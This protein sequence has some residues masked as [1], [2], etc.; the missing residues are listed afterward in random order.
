MMIEQIHDI[1]LEDQPG[2]LIVLEIR[3]NDYVL[4][5]IAR[6][7]E[8]NDAK[9]LM[10]KVRPLPGTT[11][12]E[13]TLHLNRPDIASILQAFDRYNYYVRYSWSPLE[14]ERMDLKERYDALMNYLNI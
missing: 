1:N 2:G 5:E 11:H 14:K 3:S 8:S 13:I 12:F 6:I 7:V 9:I 10:L 4:S